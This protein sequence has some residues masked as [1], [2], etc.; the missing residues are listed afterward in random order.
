M[1]PKLVNGMQAEYH[2]HLKVPERDGGIK[3]LK[4]YG[5]SVLHVHDCVTDISIHQRG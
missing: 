2:G 3:P 4:Q 5:Y 1:R